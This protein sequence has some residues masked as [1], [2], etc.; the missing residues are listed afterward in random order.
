MR[1]QEGFEPAFVAESAGAPDTAILGVDA[2][3][4]AGL[5]AADPEAFRTLFERH[6]KV[7]YNFAFRHTASWSQAEDITQATFAALWRRARNR[8]I[9]PLRGAS[10]A[11]VLL[12]MARHECL[13]N[14]R[15][16]K[17]RVNLVEKIKSLGSRRSDNVADWEAREA[18][19]RRINQVLS[20][21]PDEQR[22]VIE[23]VVWSGLDTS[24]CARVLGIP[25]GTVKSRLC[26]A[27]RK[28]A[29]TEVAHLLGGD[30]A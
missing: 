21:L 17:R 9:E 5:A 16:A 8:G 6:H 25:V 18:G 15:S 3:A 28:L 26:R 13:N 12:A 10:A 29:T 20:R 4:W 24:E 30:E 11:P 23:L 22:A 19:M 27:R 7:V 2:I 1:V 14:V